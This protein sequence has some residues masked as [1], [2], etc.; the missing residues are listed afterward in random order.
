MGDNSFLDSDTLT[1]ADINFD[2]QG[3]DYTGSGPLPTDKADQLGSSCSETGRHK[4]E[5]HIHTHYSPHGL[6]IKPEDIIS[7]I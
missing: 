1:E 2:L 6:V 7:K 4:S 5:H 3:S